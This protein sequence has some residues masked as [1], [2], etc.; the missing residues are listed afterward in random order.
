MAITGDFPLLA[1]S[2]IGDFPLEAARAGP[3]MVHSMPAR[4]IE[5]YCTTPLPV[6]FRCENSAPELPVS[7]RT[8]YRELR[9]WMASENHRSSDLD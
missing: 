5:P 8:P 4:G 1:G 7:F 9:L 2:T 3:T 6:I